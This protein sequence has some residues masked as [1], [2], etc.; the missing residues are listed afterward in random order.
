MRSLRLLFAASAVSCLVL[1]SCAGAGAKKGGGA[2]DPA[3]EDW[4]DP[5]QEFQEDGYTKVTLDLNG[6]EEPDV[7]NYYR[8]GEGSEGVRLIRKEIDLNFDGKFDS[9]QAWKDG[10]MTSEQI[11]ADFDGQ[12]DWTD[13]YSA[14]ERIRAEWD[15][16]FDGHPDMIRYYEEG[17]LARLEMDT[18]GDKS[19]DYWEYYTDGVMQ[20]AGWDLNADGKIDKWGER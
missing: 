18:T 15:T 4:V 7:I 16:S 20:R 17:K 9:V 19:V 5:V 1:T 13:F 14:G 6:N 2:T 10:E 12:F 3:D 8:D 11:D